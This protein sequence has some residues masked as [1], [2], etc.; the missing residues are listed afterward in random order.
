MGGDVI[1]VS[2]CILIGIL[3]INKIS[4]NIKIIKETCIASSDYFTLSERKIHNEF[5]LSIYSKS[6]NPNAN[7]F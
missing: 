2:F 4:F 7:F 3:G 6:E 1:V 5:F